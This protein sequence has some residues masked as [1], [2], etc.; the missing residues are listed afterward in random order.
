MIGLVANLY[1]LAGNAKTAHWNIRGSRFYGLHKLL[2][3]VDAMLREHG[4]KFAER[5]RFH[6]EMPDITLPA[7]RNLEEMPDLDASLDYEDMMESIVDGLN[8]IHDM[9]DKTRGE[10][11]SCEDS[12]LDVLQ[13]DT[14]KYVY[15]ITSIL[16]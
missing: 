1:I 7:L 8:T 11:G 6:D 5:L 15:L 12:M 4:D 13:E 9:A 3:E 10:Y 2:D 16:S 14:G